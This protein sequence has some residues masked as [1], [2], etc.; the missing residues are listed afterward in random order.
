MTRP[1]T[2]LRCARVGSSLISETSGTGVRKCER[3]AHAIHV[4]PESLEKT[5]RESALYVVICDECVH[6]PR[7][8]EFLAGKSAN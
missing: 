5:K 1:R 8:P 3:C 6:D 4:T 7:L 2:I